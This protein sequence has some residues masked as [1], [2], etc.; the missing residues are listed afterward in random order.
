MNQ[1]SATQPADAAGKILA[2][3]GKK[4]HVAEMNLRRTANKGFIATHT[5]RDKHG[6]PP[7]DGQRG[8]KEYA[9]AN[10]Q[11]LMA[12]VQQHLGGSA[13]AAGPDQGDDPDEAQ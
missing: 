12:H 10:A 8:S 4:L 13:P 2:G 11:E 7:M 1:L 3:K 5:L 6:N 9:L